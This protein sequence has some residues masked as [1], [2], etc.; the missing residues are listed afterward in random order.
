MRR[1]E[2]AVFR[3]SLEEAQEVL[4]RLE[5]SGRVVVP[6]D[7]DNPLV[8]WRHTLA[9][10]KEEGYAQVMMGDHRKV[11]A[12]HLA[13]RAVGRLNVLEVGQDVSH[14]CGDRTCINPNHLVV[15]ESVVNQSRKGCA[16]PNV[17]VVK[18]GDDDSEAFYICLCAHMP[19]C[20][21]SKAPLSLF[22]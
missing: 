11:L 17:R 8:C 4:N 3:Y 1:R 20:I 5:H 16:G 9:P 21:K 15:E 18:P 13:L 19:P 22:S 14:L 12:H 2:H 6:E 10:T 7:R